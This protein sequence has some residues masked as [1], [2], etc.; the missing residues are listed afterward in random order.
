MQLHLIKSI[1]HHFNR[2]TIF[3]FALI[4]I[5]EFDFFMTSQNKK[6]KAFSYH[7]EEGNI[8]L[9]QSD[10]DRLEPEEWFNDSLVNSYMI[11]LE[12][13]LKNPS[14]KFKTLSSHF[15]NKL[16]DEEYESVKRWMKK[17]DFFNQDA[18]I[19]PINLAKH[20]SLAIICNPKGFARPMNE[21]PTFIVLLDSMANY[22][23]KGEIK[24][25]L[26]RWVQNYLQS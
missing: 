13:S 5:T 17:F 14:F 12:S 16:V 22:H 11:H 2:F 25:T 23:N 26:K 3:F 7:L 15:Y 19:I 18:I 20:W 8:N 1:I 4:I 21:Y 10:I 24:A 9:N 6:K